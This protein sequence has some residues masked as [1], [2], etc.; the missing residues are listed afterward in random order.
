MGNSCQGKEEIK[1]FHGMRKIIAGRLGCTP[2]YVGKILS[3]ERETN[4]ETAQKVVEEAK[5]FNEI[6]K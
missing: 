4:S 2:Q 3:G 6:L 1:S 5:K